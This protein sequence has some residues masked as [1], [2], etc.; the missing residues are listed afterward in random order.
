MIEHLS[1]SSLNTFCNDIDNWHKKY[2]LGEEIIF[3]PN[4]EKA[5]EFGKEYE[6]MIG[7]VKFKGYDTQKKAREIIKWYEMYWL[8]DFFN[9]EEV[10]ECKTK[11]WWWS[12]NDIHSSWQFR[13]YNRYCK[14]YWY[15]FKIHQYNKKLRKDKTEEIGWDDP[16]FE[17]EFKEVADHIRRYLKLF[18]IKLKYYWDETVVDTL[19]DNQ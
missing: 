2:V 13:F 17:D 16:T 15:K 14:K 5:L 6:E 11:S 8:L 9:G 3:P 10:I 19:P 18:N 7:G 12:E 4:V 1:W